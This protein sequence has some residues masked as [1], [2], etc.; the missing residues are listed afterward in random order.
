[1]R[2]LLVSALLLSGCFD[3]DLSGFEPC[4]TRDQCADEQVCELGYCVLPNDDVQRCGDGKIQDGEACDD[5][6]RDNT[7]A[8]LN[9]CQ[10]A[11]CGD[12][13]L[14][15][16]VPGNTAD[17]EVCD[18]GDDLPT[19]A[20]N[21]TCKFN[22][23]SMWFD[24]EKSVGVNEDMIGWSGHVIIGGAPR[25]FEFWL[26]PDFPSGAPFDW[27]L[28]AKQPEGEA[29]NL[30]VDLKRGRESGAITGNF[31][32]RNESVA[33]I[34]VPE[35]G[36][37]HLAFTVEAIESDMAV[38][39]YL[40]GRKGDVVT[41][42]GLTDFGDQSGGNVYVGQRLGQLEVR[43]HRYR[44]AIAA[45]SIHKGVVYRNAFRPAN[46]YA[47][48]VP[49]F[50]LSWHSL[51][52][53]AAHEPSGG[54]VYWG[55]SAGGWAPFWLDDGFETIAEAPWCVI[56]WQCGDGTK[57]EFEGCDD[58]NRDDGDGCSRACQSEG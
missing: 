10:A 3:L 42:Q 36:W 28:F 19:G 39:P 44:G 48:Y 2:G 20:C 5:R 22:C 11:A 27:T 31:L 54:R 57:T 40:N 23:V 51:A 1:M 47:W 18:D 37:F 13:V 58:G 8:C 52:L 7:D 30:R 50:T 16:D 21:S 4:T 38:T 41:K 56:G 24:G 45:M 46:P 6:N 17:F 32:I 29:P 55:A 9:N 43:E 49:G 53:G 35:T 25:T 14:R 12:G 33:M 15:T 26:K 34:Q